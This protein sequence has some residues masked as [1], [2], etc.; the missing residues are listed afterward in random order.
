M[1]ILFLSDVDYFKGG[2]E[3]SLFDAMATPSITPTLAVPAKGPISEAADEKNIPVVIIDYGSVMTVRRPFKF[4]DIL[5]TFADALT[6]AQQLKA[7]AKEGGFSAVHTN[8]LKAHGIA[9]LA[10]LIGGAPVILHYRS[11]PGTV[12]EKL[13][14]RVSQIIASKLILVSRPCWP[15]KTLPKNTHV[16]FNGIELPDRS[17]LPPRLS[18]HLKE[19]PLT[20]GF[21]GRIHPSKGVHDLI[22]WFEHAYKQ[23][24]E[25]ER[26]DIRL[27]LR[28]EAAPDEPEYDAMVRQMVIDKGLSDVCIFEGRKEGYKEIYS[29]ID[30]NV[31]SSVTPDPLPRSCM[32]ASAFGIPV[33]GYPAGGI[34]DMLDDG[35]N[36]F[37]IRNG[38][39]LYSAVRRLI[40]EEGL[41]DQIS[42]AAIENAKEK[43]TLGALHASL[44]RLYK[45]LS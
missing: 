28:G 13:F 5:R 14:W 30:V 44:D 2:A 37:L 31:V 11:I 41:Y 4:T 43:F 9:C 35:V 7:A 40:E 3:R 26:L 20:L 42:N 29:N 39:D 19:Q 23:G 24:K 45:T 38:S 17:A 18:P 27:V 15:E 16:I 6:A 36:G 34:P 33:L 8:G 25:N 22:G 21:I 10:R 32:E 12:T 1:K